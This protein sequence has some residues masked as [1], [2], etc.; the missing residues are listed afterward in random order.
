[1]S[2]DRHF[3][4]VVCGMIAACLMATAASAQIITLEDDLQG[5]EPRP[6]PTPVPPLALPT[7]TPLPLPTPAPVATPSVTVPR[8]DAALE[9]LPPTAPEMPFD[10]AP[11]AV[12]FSPMDQENYLIFGPE[13]S[14]EVIDPVSDRVE[15]R[16]V[17]GE[18]VPASTRNFFLTDWV[19]DLLSL[20]GG[21][22]PASRDRFRMSVTTRGGYNSNV[23]Y[24]PDAIGSGFAELS[25]GI[26]YAVRS[27][28]FEFGLRGSGA[29]TYYDNRPGRSTDYNG[30]IDLNGFYRI[31]RRLAVRG[32]FDASYLSQPDPQIIGGTQTF[33]GDYIVTGARVSLSYLISPVMLLRPG[34]N[35]YAIRY[36]DELV[37][38]SQGFT[39]QTFSFGVD[40]LA[41]PTTTMS[42]EYRYNP[43]TYYLE[44]E[45]SEGHILTAGF[46]QQ[47]SPKLTW[48]FNGGAEYRLIQNPA[49]DATTTYLGPFVESSFT[50][51]FLPASEL[52]GRLRYGT[53]PSGQGGVTIRRTLRTSMDLTHAFTARLSLTLTAGFENSYYDQPDV[54]PDYTLDTYFAVANLRYRVNNALS[55]TA[56]YSYTTLFYSFGS[57]D[58]DVG[59][60]SFG[61]ELSF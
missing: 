11:E 20:G 9:L 32:E 6:I 15:F 16:T 43:V 61:I 31:T 24:T 39:S 22:D 18:P 2:V 53:E 36:Q 17:S 55:L 29:V 35:L 13:P 14:E 60:T 56:G 30:R 48:T 23:L 27:P 12:T 37:N 46:L 40:W 21:T 19:A 49:Q 4:E 52:T 10:P 42:V 34:Y 51:Y 38:Q 59:V 3:R 41:R 50:W 33:Q 58:Y 7:P 5:V 54:I 28:R 44:D 1:M 8:S 45:G 57:G 26:N 47:F 25:G